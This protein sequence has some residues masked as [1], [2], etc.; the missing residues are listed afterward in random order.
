MPYVL[1][2]GDKEAEQGVVAVRQ[3]TEGDLGTMQVSAFITLAKEEVANK[4][5]K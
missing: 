5:R 1:V 4:A 3:R 2:I